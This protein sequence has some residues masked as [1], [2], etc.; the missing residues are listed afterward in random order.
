MALVIITM[1][2]AV[3]VSVD[4][5]TSGDPIVEATID[6]NQGPPGTVVQVKGRCLS[7]W[8]NVRIYHKRPPES[9]PSGEGFVPFDVNSGVTPAIDGTWSTAFMVPLDMPLGPAGVTVMCGSGDAV[10]G[11]TPQFDFLVTDPNEAL[12]VTPVARPRSGTPRFTG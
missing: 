5:Q 1:I 3:N 2:F 4:A 10:I 9:D 6:V 7:E 12:P 8:G 11:I